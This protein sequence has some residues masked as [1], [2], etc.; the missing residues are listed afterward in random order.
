MRTHLQNRFT[1]WTAR[2]SCSLFLACPWGFVGASEGGQFVDVEE[3]GFPV[4][5]E[6]SELSP[7]LAADGVTLYF[8]R[9][10]PGGGQ[11]DIYTATRGEDGVFDE[12]AKL[13]GD[14]NSDFN[15]SGACVSAN[16]LTLFFHSTRP[17]P[18][19]Q[20][21]AD[22]YQ[23]TRSAIGEPFGEVINLGPEV[24][25]RF[26][27]NTPSVSADGRTLY[28]SSFR[29]G[30]GGRDLFQAS[31][32]NDEEPF[33]N[34]VNLGKLINTEF[35][36][37]GPSISPD[38]CALFFHSQRAS[39]NGGFFGLFMAIRTTTDE[40]FDRVVSLASALDGPVAELAP[41]VSPD[42]PAAGS[43]LYFA[44]ASSSFDGD[45]FQATWVPA[46]PSFLRGDCNGDSAVDISDGIFHLN[47]L[48]VADAEQ[49]TCFEACNTNNDDASDVSDAIFTF[50]FLFVAGSETP[51]APY[52][53][54]AVDPEP[55]GS[56]GCER[57]A[58]E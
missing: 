5:T 3:L 53:D 10:A 48:F 36:E 55:A 1:S 19:A 35:N 32:E 18:E 23:A 34:V 21:E 33:G 11:L 42:W 7:R 41:S 51:A 16:G 54:C 24:N 44:Q 4:N 2:F 47:A 25:S 12:V 46:V 26:I 43:V 20:G 8:G 49:T 13:E 28:F 15:D 58:C 30:V 40:P 52:P 38:G 9:R 22:L 57:L 39:G 17:G 37:G 29:P 56:L 14:V 27:D 50:N 45:L 6:E 31:R